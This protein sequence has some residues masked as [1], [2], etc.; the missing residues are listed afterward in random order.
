[1]NKIDIVTMFVSNL[2]VFGFN[3][4]CIC[5]LV[6]L[7]L[8]DKAHLKEWDLGYQGMSWVESMHFGGGSWSDICVLRLGL[9]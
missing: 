4:L 3:Q 1:M 2:K 9:S 7:L 8:V 6:K 5:R